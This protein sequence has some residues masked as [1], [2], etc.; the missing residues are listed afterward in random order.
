MATPD[1]VTAMDR[2]TALVWVGLVAAAIGG[3]QY[4]GLGG[5]RD[6]IK[7]PGYGRDPN[8]N[9][10]AK[11]WERT[12]TVDQLAAVK[13][14]CDFILPAEGSAPAASALHVHDFID[15]WVSA[16]Y[17]DQ[18]ADRNIFLD[19]LEWL[20]HEASRR[21]GAARFTAAQ[22]AVR[23][24]IMVDLAEG[25]GAG[26]VAPTGFWPKFRK[27]VIGA[28][29]TTEA[30]FADIGFIGNVAQKSFPLPSAEVVAQIN[31][32]ADRLGLPA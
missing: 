12:L 3:G 29:Y 8:L 18:Q 16:P 22:P 20:D 32:A 19:A 15:E 14:L 5:S 25:K 17:P 21:A 28:Y 27:L 24:A 9:D 31:A 4:L 2:R 13:L 7:G 30:G 26:K 6:P 23:E 11:Y 10:P 1:K